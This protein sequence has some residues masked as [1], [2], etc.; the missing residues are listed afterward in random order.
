M[1]TEAIIYLIV[2]FTG[3][4]IL[5]TFNPSS[6]IFNTIAS[7]PF[8]F[9][10]WFYLFLLVHTF[11]VLDFSTKE[12]AITI[13]TMVLIVFVITTFVSLRKR[14]LNIKEI[15]Y[16]AL[17]SVFISV[18]ALFAVYFQ[19]VILSTDNYQKV[20]LETPIGITLNK[21]FPI[22]GVA[23]QYFGQII[24]YDYLFGHPNIFS[25]ISLILLMGYMLYRKL[26]PE[27][28]M[29]KYALL[30]FIFLPGVAL[31][32]TFVGYFHF[33]YLNNH[34]LTALVY[35]IL[36]YLLQEYIKN[37]RINYIYTVNAL[38]F[39]LVFLR[40]EGYLFSILFIFFFFR[41]KDIPVSI[42]KQVSLVHFL[43]TTPWI[44]FTII[45]SWGVHS[46]VNTNLQI[47]SLGIGFVLYLF[48][49]LKGKE[50]GI[51][52]FFWNLKPFTMLLSIVILYFIFLSIKPDHMLGNTRTLVLNMFYKPGKWIPFWAF[53]IPI[54]IYIIIDRKIWLSNQF[55]D[56]LVSYFYIAFM[57]TFLLSFFRVAL[58]PDLLDSIN[59]MII[60]F[61]PMLLVW[62]FYYIGI[63]F[64]KDTLIAPARS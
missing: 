50:I 6:I 64:R 40:M 42:G 49:V 28:D 5:R 22:Y 45:N 13:M 8:A 41:H 37:K 4:F 17:A 46:Y 33:F 9:M 32:T 11:P 20:L 53:I 27:L 29:P 10:L 16:I 47:I 62:L 3:F 7:F 36:F 61:T 1:H 34:V 2:F 38:L 55:L 23:L 58:R 25:N 35:L 24:D 19:P 63:Y 14:K 21:G 56:L 30:I 60:H 57:L 48:F 15:K 31:Y 44:I 59:R 54:S 39:F 52:N 12:K 18:L 43:L 51:I 26:Q